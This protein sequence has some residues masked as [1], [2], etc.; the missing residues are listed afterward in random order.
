MPQTIIT[1]WQKEMLPVDFNQ[2][3]SNLLIFIYEELRVL[4]N[5]HQATI[6]RYEGVFGQKH[7]EL[8]KN[9]T[10]AQVW[11][12]ACKKIMTACKSLRGDWTCLCG[13]DL[14]VRDIVTYQEPLCPACRAQYYYII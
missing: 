3:E 11:V 2:Q 9:A 6:D 7:P 8:Q 12:D 13:K 4:R 1:Y 14:L 10:K 5:M